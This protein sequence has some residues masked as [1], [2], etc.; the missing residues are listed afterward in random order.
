[1]WRAAYSCPEHPQEMVSAV[2][3]LYRQG[4][5]V[6]LRAQ[7]RLHSPH[8]TPQARKGEPVWGRTAILFPRSLVDTSTDA[9][10]GFRYEGCPGN[11]V[12]HLTH[13]VRQCRQSRYCIRLAIPKLLKRRRLAAGAML[14]F[15]QKDEPSA[16]SRSKPKEPDTHRRE[17][18]G[19]CVRA[20]HESRMS[21]AFFQ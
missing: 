10:R 19:R 14:H 4:S 5:Q 7:I 18:S 16:E 6:E 11:N 3:A 13:R 2:A 15:Q 17:G 12:F 1:M 8:H 20:L 9:R 21:R